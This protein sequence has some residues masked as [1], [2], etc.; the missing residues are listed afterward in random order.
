MTICTCTTPPGGK[1]RCES[2]QIAI[3]RTEAGECNTICVDMTNELKAKLLRGNLG[4]IEIAS[5]ISSI[6]GQEYTV[7]TGATLVSSDRKSTV[8]YT[9]PSIRGQ[10]HPQ[11]IITST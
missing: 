10:G 1:G 2:N 5:L 3:C 8:R 11:D 4:P 7:S 9:L 6:F